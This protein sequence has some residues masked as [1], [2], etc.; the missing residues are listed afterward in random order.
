MIVN[1]GIRF[2]SIGCS[3]NSLFFS[4]VF[5]D[6]DANIAID[7]A[8]LQPFTE[9]EWRVNQELKINTVSLKMS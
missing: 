6:G 1:E 8:S 9:E 4:Q 2:S 7:S 3:L 5:D